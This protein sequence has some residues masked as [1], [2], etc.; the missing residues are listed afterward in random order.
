MKWREGR[1][2]GLRWPPFGQDNNQPIVG[3]SGGE[4][5]IGET[6]PVQNVWGDA[7]SL[8]WSLK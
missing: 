3:I 2:P 5:T 8:L 7:V 1:G 4:G 6:Q